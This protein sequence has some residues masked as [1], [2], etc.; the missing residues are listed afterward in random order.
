MINVDTKK[1]MINNWNDFVVR[2]WKQR[3]NELEKKLNIK[4]TIYRTIANIREKKTEYF[5][6]NRCIES[7]EIGVKFGGTFETCF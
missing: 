7:I 3:E 6:K 4:I 1:I 2:C 5:D